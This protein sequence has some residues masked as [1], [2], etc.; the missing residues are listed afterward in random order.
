V[1]RGYDFSAIA[2]IVDVGGGQ[3][4]MLARILAAHPGLHGTLLELPHA[5]DGACAHLARAGV[6][7]RCEV[8]VG[9]FFESIPAGADAYLLK[10]ILHNWDDTA[11]AS[12][13]HQCRDAMAPHAALLVIERI[14]PSPGVA[15]AWSMARADLNMLA[16]LGGRERTHDE[17]EKLLSE[18]GFSLLRRLPLSLDFSLLEARPR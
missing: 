8:V 7:E 3:G 1:V 15:P 10:A 17:F 2:R 9:S 6:L 5:R 13:L 14:L 16:A 12:L 11:C 18:G 4:E